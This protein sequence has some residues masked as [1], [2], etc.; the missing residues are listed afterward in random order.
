[1][2]ILEASQIYVGV[3]LVTVGLSYTKIGQTKIG[4]IFPLIA[5]GVH[6]WFAYVTGLWPFAVL[7]LG[8]IILYTIALLISAKEA[9]N[10]SKS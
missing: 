7:G 6:F 5:G 3:L 4:F 9:I 2:S 1:M 10:A 8:F